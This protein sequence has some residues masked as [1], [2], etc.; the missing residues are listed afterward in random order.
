MLA[1]IIP[2]D[3]LA[4]SHDNSHHRRDY[5]PIKIEVLSTGLSVD[6]VVQVGRLSICLL[7]TRMSLRWM[8]SAAIPSFYCGRRMCAGRYRLSRHLSKWLIIKFKEALTGEYFRKNLF[9]FL[10]IGSMQR[11]SFG[12]NR[13]TQGHVISEE[14]HATLN[15]S[16]LR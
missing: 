1:I 9:L 13:L 6:F 14:N 10:S 7:Y 11:T 16:T 8:H 4:T 3:T 5:R 12:V 15:Q 2:S